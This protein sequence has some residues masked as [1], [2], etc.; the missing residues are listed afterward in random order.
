[1]KVTDKKNKVLRDFPNIQLTH[2]DSM[3][4][5]NVDGL[6][7]QNI[8]YVRNHAFPGCYLFRCESR[9]GN[10]NYFDVEKIYEHLVNTIP[11][12]E[13]ME[14]IPYFTKNA[15]K[16]EDYSNF[17]L[18]VILNKSQIY[19]RIEKD[20]SESYVLF[21]NK[22]I[23]NVKKF[24]AMLM[25]YYTPPKEESNRFFR[26]AM[27]REGYYL[28]K[29]RIK[30]V[31]NFD[32]S[33]TYNDSFVKEDEKIRKFIEEDNQGGLVILHGEKGTGKSTY[34]K[35]LISKYENRK[36]VYVPSSFIDNMGD[37]SFGSFLNTLANHVIILEDC[38]NALR[39]RKTTHNSSAVSLLLN[40]TDG[41]LSDDLGIKFI[42]TFNDDL[43][44]IDS[45]L[46]RKGR[47]VSKYEF[48]ALDK[49]KASALL[50]ER[51]FE[52]DASKPMTLSDIF[53]YEEDSYDNRKSIIGFN[54]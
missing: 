19:A 43:R 6:S 48:K 45:A 53:Y 1:M 36:F 46:T 33:K 47:L 2:E 51:G 26:L 21:N 30:T 40:M 32:I 54:E 4:F 17:T 15:D 34:I 10:G 13:K 28:E 27:S 44:N 23:D 22:D 35:Y 41:I 29:G 14:I 7:L 5:G 39:D 9:G 52:E 31:E 11:D 24:V 38:E 18:C 49:E 25:E 20:L 3:F 8:F 16:S 42:C 12:D 37:P 50:H